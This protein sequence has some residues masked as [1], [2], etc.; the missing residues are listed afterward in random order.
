MKLFYPEAAFWQNFRLIRPG[1]HF[2]SGTSLP[3]VSAFARAEGFVLYHHLLILGG[4]MHEL[5]K[6]IHQHPQFNIKSIIVSAHL[7]KL[8]VLPGISVG[9]DRLI[10]ALCSEDMA[11]FQ[12]ILNDF[13]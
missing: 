7:N 4:E 8:R 11:H 2:D 3:G 6:M 9:P 10:V 1:S 5:S 12:D 13:K